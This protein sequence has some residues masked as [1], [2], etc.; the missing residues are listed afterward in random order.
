M[1]EISFSTTDNIETIS[2]FL[3]WV[4]S[5]PAPMNPFRTG[6]LQGPGPLFLDLMAQGQDGLHFHP[7]RQIQQ[8]CQILMGCKTLTVRPFSSAV[9]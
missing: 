8:T 2:A 4:L 1:P 6:F 3:S 9:I 7:F 5:H